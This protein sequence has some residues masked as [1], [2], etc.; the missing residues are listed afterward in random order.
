MMILPFG[1]E[2]VTRTPD[3]HVP[4]VVRYQLRYF[5]LTLLARNL[6][7]VRLFHGRKAGNPALLYSRNKSPTFA[8]SRL[9][10][11]KAGAKLLHFFDIRKF[12]VHFNEKK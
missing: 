5:S 2:E 8:N 3:P 10:F 6:S 9:F 12:F 1:R 4:N 7:V 11:A